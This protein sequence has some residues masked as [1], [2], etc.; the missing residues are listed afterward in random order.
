MKVTVC[1]RFKEESHLSLRG[2][3]FQT[4]TRDGVQTRMIQT[5]AEFIQ[6][7]CEDFGLCFSELARL[8]PRVWASHLAWQALEP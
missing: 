1:Q 8:W 6:M 2:A 7:L 4:V 3:T 5:R